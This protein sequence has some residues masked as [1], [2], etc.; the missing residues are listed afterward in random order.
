MHGSSHEPAY[1]LAEVIEQLGRSGR[2][3]SFS[4]GLNPAQW[5][6]LRYFSQANRFSRTVGAFAQYHG[7]TRGTASQT[8]KA[9]V[10]KGFLCQSRVERDRRS[11][12]FDL[13]AKARRSLGRDP[14]RILVS[15]GRVLSDSQCL[16][17][18]Q[19]LE[20]MRESVLV[21]DGGWLFGICCH[22]KYLQT[23]SYYRGRRCYEC[24]KFSEPLTLGETEELCVNFAPSA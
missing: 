2:C 3:A 16:K 4:S 17:V 5:A 15:A 7:T 22:C 24:A 18:L 13:S 11:V 9:L 6:A 20:A 23:E 14:I 12:R 1:R 10:Q 21:Q 19:A 8:T